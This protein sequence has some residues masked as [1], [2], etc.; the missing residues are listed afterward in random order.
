MAHSISWRTDTFEA[1]PVA[2]D[3]IGL[4]YADVQNTRKAVGER[5]RTEHVMTDVEATSGNQGRHIM[6]SARVFYFAN[7]ADLPAVPNVP[8]YNADDGY[9]K[10]RIAMTRWSDPDDV[11]VFWYKLLVYKSDAEGAAWVE[12]SYAHTSDVA[13]TLQGLKTFKVRPKVADVTTTYVDAASDDLLPKSII[14]QRIA[15]LT[16]T[17]RDVVMPVGF[18]YAQLP[19]YAAP[20]TLW[21]WAT[22]AAVDMNGAFPRFEGTGA[23]GFGAGE[24]EQEIGRHTHSVTHNNG[25]VVVGG[26]GLD[27]GFLF[28]ANNVTPLSVSISETGGD[29]NRPR[30]VTVRVWRR[31]L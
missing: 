4:V 27:I 24:Q 10:G 19:G 2:A 14:E 3:K 1:K 5:F 21:P 9:A 29:E 12:P 11:G 16:A 30:N 17:I 28:G 18:I 8:V 6:G 26:S 20:A 13:E 25:K 22:W 15:A 31:T 23:K 7:A